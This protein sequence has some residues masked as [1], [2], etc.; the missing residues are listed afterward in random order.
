MDLKPRTQFFKFCA[1]L[2][3]HNISQSLTKTQTRHSKYMER[4]VNLKGKATSVSKETMT[5][6]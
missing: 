6:L 5:C 4:K 2:G 1:L 3:T